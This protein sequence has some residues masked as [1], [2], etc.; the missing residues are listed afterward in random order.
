MIVASFGCYLPFLAMIMKQ[1]NPRVP[2]FL[3]LGSSNGNGPW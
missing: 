1:P 3:V 2:F